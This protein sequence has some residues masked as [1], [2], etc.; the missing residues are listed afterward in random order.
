MSLSF[1]RRRMPSFSSSLAALSTSLLVG[2][3]TQACT[4]DWDAY[5]PRLDSGE[6]NS[7]SSSGIGGMGEASSS[8]SASMGGG[9]MGQSSSSSSV[10][11]GGAGGMM[12][13]GG[14]GGAGGAGGMGGMGGSPGPCGG[15]YLVSEDFAQPIDT[16]W[17]W[18]VYAGPGT[19][20][21]L[22]NGQWRLRL[23]T[24][25]TS[26]H[27][28]ML[29]SQ[30]AYDLRGTE[31]FVE[32]L[33]V[34]NPATA[35]QTSLIAIYDD[36]NNIRFQYEQGK[37]YAAYKK[38]DVNMIKAQFTFDPV[39]HRYWRMREQSG[40]FYWETSPDGM[41]WTIRSQT[42]LNTLPP[43][44]AVYFLIDVF[45]SGAY[46]SPGE[47]RYDNI[48]R[49]MPPMGNYCP[50]GSFQDNFDDNVTGHVWDRSDEDNGCTYDETGGELVIMPA[51]STS[52]YCGYTSASAYDLRS[53]SATVEVTKTPDIM[54]DTATYFTLEG[55]GGFVEI[56]QEGANLIM[57]YETP[58]TS[59]DLAAIP[60]NAVQH[61]WWRIR[62]KNGTT[63][64]ETSPNG[65]TWTIGAQ[66]ANPLPLD[67]LDVSLAAGTGST[68]NNPGEAHF[69]HF[70]FGP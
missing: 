46:S 57:R 50:V 55:K 59:A 21:T 39:Q 36:A 3:L 35:A 7:S 65:T 47:A 20:S 28:A 9:G 58:V 56:A 6:A 66:T 61:R 63:Y 70:N 54:E 27:Y 31:M 60:Y 34:P 67:M 43:I 17:F 45:V 26:D 37:L 15:M 68:V 5:D 13:T 64:W 41:N 30:R 29:L 12:A 23:P 44:D 8:S 25:S 19:S 38:D 24:N 62:E 40:A 48:N 14:M 2:A 33:T 53:T 52:A 49:G 51:T 22:D 16:T 4:F 42:P 11:M 69:D 1:R 32:N 18:E 10:A